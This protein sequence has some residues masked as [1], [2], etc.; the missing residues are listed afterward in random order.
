MQEATSTTC[1]C[2]KVYTYQY[3][4][5]T[6]YLNHTIILPL[7][8]LTYDNKLAFSVYMYSVDSQYFDVKLRSNILMYLGYL[9]VNEILTHLLDY[10]FVMQPQSRKVIQCIQVTITLKDAHKF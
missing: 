7:V 1:Y 10:I 2:C 3:V 4:D 9:A 5:S 6:F 8:L